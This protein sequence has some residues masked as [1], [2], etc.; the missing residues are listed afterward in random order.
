MDSE[1]RV[2]CLSF[3]SLFGFGHGGGGG[4]KKTEEEKQKLD[5][6]ERWDRKGM[7]LG[8]IILLCKYIILI[9]CMIK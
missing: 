7:I 1:A 9:C 2:V 4:S 6:W 3:G 5:K 8:Y